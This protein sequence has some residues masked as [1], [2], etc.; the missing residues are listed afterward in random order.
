LGDT[1]TKGLVLKFVLTKDVFMSRE[2]T[3]RK[4]MP[5][6][7]SV[8]AAAVFLALAAP[9]VAFASGDVNPY[10]YGIYS[11]KDARGKVYRY[12]P[13][14]WYYR[15][16]GYYP[17]KASR[18]WVP[19]AEMRYRYRYQYYGP[20]YQYHPAWDYPWPTTDCCQSHR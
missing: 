16:S 3:R 19:R 7:F 8:S 2:A 15:P 18:Y 6:K 11:P 13:R 1:G 10:E 4:I 9:G 14:S 17:S 5:A 12:D 20:G